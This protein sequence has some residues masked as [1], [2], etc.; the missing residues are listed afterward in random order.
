MK[1]GRAAAWVVLTVLLTACASVPPS[2]GGSSGDAVPV[3]AGS[4][5]ARFI[6][7]T[8]FSMRDSFINRDSHG[9]IK[10]VSG[11][12]YLGYKQLA[13]ALAEEFADPDGVGLTVEVTDLAIEEPRVTAIVSWQRTGEGR[14]AVSG[15]TDLIFQM[16]DTLSLVNVQGDPLFGLEGF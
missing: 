13:R 6:R 11:G 5:E 4:L 12:F 14:A 9:F 3:A 10:H 7:Q 1:D 8:V 16:G 15:T 2:P